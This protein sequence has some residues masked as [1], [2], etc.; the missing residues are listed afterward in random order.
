MPAFALTEFAVV[1]TA[2]EKVVAGFQQK[3][4]V[5]KYSLFLFMSV[6]PFRGVSLKQCLFCSVLFNFVAIYKF[7]A[8]FLIFSVGCNSY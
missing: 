4:R 6:I 7:L 5:Q 8:A 3:Q 2:N 1:H